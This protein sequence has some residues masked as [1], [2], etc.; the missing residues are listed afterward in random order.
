MKKAL[1]FCLGIAVTVPGLWAG[2]HPVPL[3]AKLDAAKCVEC[4]VANTCVLA[5]HGYNHNSNGTVS[6]IPLPTS[7]L[8]K[9]AKSR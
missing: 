4:H 5:C 9:A 3:E 6:A 1:L 7:P 2:K 8:Q